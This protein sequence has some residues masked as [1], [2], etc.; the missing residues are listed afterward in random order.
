M[1]ERVDRL[2]SDFDLV[3]LAERDSF[4]G[5]QIK[6]VDTT[7]GQRIAGGCGN[8]TGATLHIVGVGSVKGRAGSS[9]ND[10]TG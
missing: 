9:A 7:G 1:I 3:A 8:G 5:A 2:H 4:E 10:G 6:V